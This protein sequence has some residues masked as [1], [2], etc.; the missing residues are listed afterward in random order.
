M[1]NYDFKIQF[2]NVISL[3]H[4]EYDTYEVI[5]KGFPKSEANESA[6][7]IIENSNYAKNYL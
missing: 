4:A 6:F 5:N 1:E 2:N 3:F 7:E